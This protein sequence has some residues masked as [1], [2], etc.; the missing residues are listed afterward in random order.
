MHS[1][2]PT[3]YTYDSLDFSDSI[4]IKYRAP[5]QDRDFGNKKDQADRCDRSRGTVYFAR[6]LTCRTEL[7]ISQVRSERAHAYWLL[8]LATVRTFAG[9]GVICVT[10]YV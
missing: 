4:A 9:M 3:L 10:F 1:T 7:N 2:L 8:C 6:T 5:S